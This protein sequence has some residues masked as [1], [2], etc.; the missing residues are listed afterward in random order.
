M[1]HDIQEERVSRWNRWTKV[2]SM[3]HRG[4]GMKSIIELAV[5]SLSGMKEEAPEWE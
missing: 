3:R 2:E 5:D 1:A 4:V